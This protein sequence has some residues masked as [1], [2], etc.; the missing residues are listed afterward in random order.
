MKLSRLLPLLTAAMLLLFA[1]ASGAEFQQIDRDLEQRGKFK[2]AALFLRSVFA[3][4]ENAVERRQLEFELDR[5]DRI[6]LDFPLTREALFEKLKAAVRDLSAAEFLK[7]IGEKRFDVRVIDGQEW[8]M[9]S[10]VANLF[11]RYPELSARRIS[12]KDQSFQKA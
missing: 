10:S 2:E 4:N 1:K 9:T 12:P 7:W 11:W 8:F 6:R 5:L 3:T